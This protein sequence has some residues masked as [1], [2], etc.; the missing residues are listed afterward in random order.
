MCCIVFYFE[1]HLYRNIHNMSH[2]TI[3]RL[4][5]LIHKIAV[6]AENME[7]VDQITSELASVCNVHTKSVVRWI[8]NRNQP[9]F[10]TINKIMSHLATYDDTLSMSDF[11]SKDTPHS[12]P[13]KHLVK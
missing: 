2:M 5:I 3:N 13:I 10:P 7:L 9:S 8:S 1:Q 11:F 4:S 6:N 12:T